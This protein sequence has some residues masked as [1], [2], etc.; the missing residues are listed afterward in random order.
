MLWTTF[1][2]RG[3]GPRPS[4]VWQRTGGLVLLLCLSVRPHL[5][6]QTTIYT[7]TDEKGV[8]HYSDSTV[9][10]QHSDTV[11]RVTVPARPLPAAPEA[12]RAES[13]PLV[14]LH[15]DASQKFVQAVLEGERTSREVLMLVDTGAQITLIDEE[16]AEELAL[17]HIQ[18]ALLSGVTGVAHG[19]IGRLPRLRLGNETVSDLP[20]MV[21][22]LPGRLLLGMDVLEHLQLSVGPRS[23]DRV[24]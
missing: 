15:D 14:I 6:A 18:D 12:H 17:E 20:V 7:W 13:I 11:E 19:W 10:A 22:P 21:A 16:L 1:A 8:Q 23:L 24:K 3:T 2:K 4:P 9:P 5:W